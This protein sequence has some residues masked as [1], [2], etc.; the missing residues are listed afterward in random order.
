M[1]WQLFKMPNSFTVHRAGSG[2]PDSHGKS[3]THTPWGLT[4]IGALYLGD[5]FKVFNEEHQPYNIYYWCPL[6]G[7][8]G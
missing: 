7:R 8:V 5:L 1:P 4:L 2:L 6:K 3:H